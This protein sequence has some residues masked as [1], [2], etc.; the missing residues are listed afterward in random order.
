LISGLFIKR[1]VKQLTFAG[2]PDLLVTFGP[3]I[4]PKVPNNHGRFGYLYPK[5][6]TDDGLY[7]VFT[8]N[9]RNSGVKQLQNCFLICTFI[10]NLF[11]R[12]KGVD[13]P[14]KLNFIDRLNGEEKLSLWNSDECNSLNNTFNGQLHPPLVDNFSPN[15]Q[16]FN[17]LFGRKFN[18]NFDSVYEPYPGTVF[19]SL[20]SFEYSTDFTNQPDSIGRPQ[21]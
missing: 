16:F 7:N 1:S 11:S 15:Y 9:T 19:L 12:M 10:L 18:L 2:Y 4:D 3:M 8:G 14:T 17:E 5:N 20:S 6:N 13:D 21:V